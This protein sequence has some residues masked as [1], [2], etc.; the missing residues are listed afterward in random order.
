[1]NNNEHNNGYNIQH[2]HEYNRERRNAVFWIF[3]LLAFMGITGLA[4]KLGLKK[5]GY[6][7]SESVSKSIDSDHVFLKERIF[8]KRNNACQACVF[9]KSTCIPDTPT[10]RRVHE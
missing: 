2:N 8:S 3:R 5:P 1:M 4:V 10:C 9:C 6:I 7:L